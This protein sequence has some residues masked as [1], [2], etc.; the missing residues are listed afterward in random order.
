MPASD[1]YYS[2][3]Q[4]LAFERGEEW[5]NEYINGHIYEMPRVGHDHILIVGNVSAEIGMQLKGKPSEAY[6]S[7]MRIKVSRTGLYTYPDVVAV[8]SKPLFEDEY[9]DTL[10]NPTIIVE[11]LSPS[12]EAHD[13]GEKFAHYRRLD[14]LMEYV[15]VA[16]DTMRVEHYTRHGSSGDEWVLREISTPDGTLQLHSIDC[17]VALSDIYDKVQFSS[18]ENSPITRA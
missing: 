18:D 1:V 17:A 7:R 16:Q 5:K 8:V 11:V 9:K 2:Q 14:S 10:I 6:A 3:E 4:Y 13:R 15:L 12:T